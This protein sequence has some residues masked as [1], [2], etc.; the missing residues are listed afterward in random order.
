MEVRGRSAGGLTLPAVLCAIAEYRARPSVGDGST[1]SAIDRWITLALCERGAAREDAARQLALH[2]GARAQ[3]TLERLLLADDF[4][5]AIAMHALL[6]RG[7]TDVLERIVD[8]A[9]PSIDATEEIA[10]T[11]VRR[12]LPSSVWPQQLSVLQT[13]PRHASAAL[14][15]L[16]R[17]PAR[18]TAGPWRAPDGEARPPL[19]L[20]T[21]LLSALALAALLAAR[22]A[23][24][25]SHGRS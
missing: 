6:R 16:A 7:S 21:L 18:P 3:D 2:P 25:L 1:T 5:R 17:P 9:T 19:P 15:E 4:T 11:A 20:V 8:A 10:Q 14:R 24:S 12:W 23:S 13:L 22:C